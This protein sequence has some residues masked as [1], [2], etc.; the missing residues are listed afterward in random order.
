MLSFKTIFRMYS[1]G[2]KITGNGGIIVERTILKE[3]GPLMLQNISSLT[4]FNHYLK[5]N[6]SRYNSD[7]IE[8]SPMVQQI[9]YQ[10][11][12]ESY[13]R[14][15]KWYLIPPCLTLSII[16][17]V[18]RVKWSNPGKGVVLSPTLRCSSYWKGSLRVSLDYSRQLCFSA[19]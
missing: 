4:N 12:V 18:L 19:Y 9:G 11:Q 14:L 13:Q 5:K 16:R 3:T 8:L 7:G 15:K 17:Y 10:S 2:G 6:P 1:T